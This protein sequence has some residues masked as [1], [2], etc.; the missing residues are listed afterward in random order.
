MKCPACGSENLA[1]SPFCPACGRKLAASEPPTKG[2]NP[3]IATIL[4]FFIPAGGQL[5]NGD[6]KKMALIWFTYI[7]LIALWF[8]LIG[9]LPALLVGFVVWG[10]AILDAYGVAKGQGKRW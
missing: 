6:I 3:F 9:M 1:A 2:K 7:F 4:S 5:Y 10:W 8:T